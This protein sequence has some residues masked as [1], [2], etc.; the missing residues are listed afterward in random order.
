MWFGTFLFFLA[1]LF[2]STQCEEPTYKKVGS[3]IVLE[4]DR[5][6]SSVK[7]IL[8]KQGNNLAM[9]YY[10]T[11]DSL[12]SYRQ[13]EVRGKLDTTNGAMTIKELTRDDSGLY[14]VEIN[15][16][17][18]KMIN[19]KVIDPVPKPNIATSCHGD[20]C[21]LT[22]E[23]D[24]VRAQ[25]VTYVWYID[26]KLSQIKD[27]KYTITKDENVVLIQ[28]ELENPVSH[29]QS[30]IL[31]NPLKSTVDPVTASSA[32]AIIGAVVGILVLALCAGLVLGFLHKRGIF[33]IC[34]AQATGPVI[35]YEVARQNDD[36]TANRPVAA[37]KSDGD[38]ANGPESVKVE[39][40]PSADPTQRP[41]GTEPLL[42]HIQPLEANVAAPK[43]DDDYENIP[44]T[45]PKS[46]DDYENVPASV[47][48]EPG[49]SA[50]PTQ[51]PNGTE[52]IVPADVHPNTDKDTGPAHEDLTANSHDSGEAPTSSDNQG[53]ADSSEPTNK[54]DDDGELAPD[55][56]LQEDERE[57][58]EG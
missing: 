6:T 47:N 19:L 41:N 20:D 44:V 46:D 54:P 23:G 58:N 56:K 38:A 15:N 17:V 48:V 49:P 51:R 55:K 5:T 45:A 53:N 29:Q 12:S 30:D 31:H 36:D 3:E 21:D 24:T 7:T 32:G 40:G 34:P 25:P 14:T 33:R 16:L 1:L 8:W 9:E 22:C 42:L 2:R 13:F 39:P 27:K 18:N 35:N 43:S 37:P 57:D 28:C 10:G 26:K 50:D 4:P 11:P 52:V